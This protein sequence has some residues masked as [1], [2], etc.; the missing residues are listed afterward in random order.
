MEMFINI[1]LNSVDEAAKNLKFLS[2]ELNNHYN[3][4]NGVDCITESSG[5]TCTSINNAYRQLKALEF[6]LKLLVENTERAVEE[7]GIKVELTDEDFS[8]RYRRILNPI[9]IKKW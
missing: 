5:S 1:N 9:E 4:S 6:V 3:A 7:S 2:L 8:K